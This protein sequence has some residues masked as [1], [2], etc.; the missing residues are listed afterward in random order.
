MRLRHRCVTYRILGAPCTPTMRNPGRPLPYL[1]CQCHRVLF[2]RGPYPRTYLRV[3]G[4]PAASVDTTSSESWTP[5]SLNQVSSYLLPSSC[6]GADIS[7]TSILSATLFGD[8]CTKEPL[9]R[10]RLALSTST[11]RR[12][13]D[14]SIA[15]GNGG[16]GRYTGAPTTLRTYGKRF[17]FVHRRHDGCKQVR[18]HLSAHA[19]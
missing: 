4:L 19:E 12:R 15:K 5:R 7:L 13:R 3:V 14:D 11:C 16:A 17:R 6:F 10:R 8:P 9:E 2:L 1:W 18:A